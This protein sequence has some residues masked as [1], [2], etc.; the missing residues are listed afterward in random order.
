MLELPVFYSLILSFWSPF[1][2][3]NNWGIWLRGHILMFLEFGFTASLTR[4]R[5]QAL[6]Y[7]YLNWQRGQ[8]DQGL[9]S[10]VMVNI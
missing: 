9:R 5:S 10:A 6:D 7:C 8:S 4:L 1:V 2:G 3:S